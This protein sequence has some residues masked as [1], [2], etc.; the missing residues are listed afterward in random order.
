MNTNARITLME[1]PIGGSG[2]VWNRLHAEREDICEALIKEGRIGFGVDLNGIAGAGVT[3]NDQHREL[4]QR[5]L[6]KVDDA[7]DRVMSGTYGHC[8]QCNREIESDSLEFDPALAVCRPCVEQAKNNALLAD[9]GLERVNSNSNVSPANNEV[10]LAGLHSFDTILVRTLN[11]DYRILLLDPKTGRA[12]VEGGKYFVEP[13]EAWVSGSTLHDARFKAGSIAVGYHLEMW[14]DD[15][16][17]RTSRV[18]SVRVK[19]CDSV[20]SAEAITAAIR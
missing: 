12:L 17:V 4:M 16:F 3:N 1:I 18:Q 14:V 15:N 8:R 11:T 7:L 9:T 20:E 6:R 13:R 2:L 19:H 10:V 5:R